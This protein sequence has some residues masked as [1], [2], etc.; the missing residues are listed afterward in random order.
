M[1]EERPKRNGGGE[2]K[3]DYDTREG[4]GRYRHRSPPRTRRPGPASRTSEASLSSEVVQLDFQG[5]DGSGGRRSSDEQGRGRRGGEEIVWK[6]ET[7][8]GER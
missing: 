5:F 2:G 4:C 8:W 6:G 1:T 3:N 7:V